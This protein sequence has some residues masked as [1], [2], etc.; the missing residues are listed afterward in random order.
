GLWE[1]HTSSPA[2]RGAAAALRCAPDRRDG[3]PEWPLSVESP[4]SA[5]AAAG[6]LGGPGVAGRGGTPGAGPE[7]RNGAHS[8]GSPGRGAAGAGR[9][10]GRTR[11]AAREVAGLALDRGDRR[12]DR[13]SD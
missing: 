11:L 8:R 3:S 13:V 9:E 10:Y 5:A 12:A 2:G 4:G 7:C 1:A 6:S